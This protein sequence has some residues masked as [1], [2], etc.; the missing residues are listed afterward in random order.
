LFAFFNAVFVYVTGPIIGYRDLPEKDIVICKVS[1]YL[2]QLFEASTLKKLSVFLTGL[3]QIRKCY[4]QDLLES[5][6]DL[7]TFGVLDLVRCKCMGN[8]KQIKDIY[9]RLLASDYL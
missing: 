1:Q 8:K 9:D 5:N 6:L 4:S 3:N 2:N 7:I